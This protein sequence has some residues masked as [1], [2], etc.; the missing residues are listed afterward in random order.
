M[1]GKES[2]MGHQA[3]PTRPADRA[4]RSAGELARDLSELVPRLVREELKL[5]RA[6]MTAKAKRA[7]IG[8]GL[9]GGSGVV[10]LLGVACLLACVI[11]AISLAL[12]VWAAALI[13]GAALLAVAGATALVGTASLR[14]STPPI[15]TQAIGTVQDDIRE[16][17]QRAQ[18]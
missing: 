17:K 5:A 7:G 1:Q 18:R 16:I 4:E 13:V 2:V 6:E 15:P 3:D 8:A 12:P 11:A 10:A 14:S 9:L